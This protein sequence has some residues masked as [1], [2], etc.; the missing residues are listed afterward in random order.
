VHLRADIEPTM[1]KKSSP[2]SDAD[3]KGARRYEVD[4][5]AFAAELEGITPKLEACA[6]RLTR[7]APD[8]KQA[9]EDL[10][11]ETRTRCWERRHQFR[12][13]TS[14]EYWARRVMKN[15]RT[16]Q[17]RRKR[18]T[19]VPLDDVNEGVL[20]DHRFV[21]GIEAKLTLQS[22]LEKYT[23]VSNQN[24]GFIIETLGERMSYSEIAAKAGMRLGTVGSSVSRALN[25]LMEDRHKLL[26]DGE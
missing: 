14:M 19:L 12:P 5:D 22:I 11:Q 6:R 8:R 24:F 25:R 4:D 3:Q 26:G 21:G 2:P 18:L 9:A 20:A 16:D 10:L 17:A 23:E 15:I 13:G 7:R 1:R